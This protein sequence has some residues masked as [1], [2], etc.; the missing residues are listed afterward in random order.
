MAADLIPAHSLLI[1]AIVL[2]VGF[3]INHSVIGTLA[4]NCYPTPFVVV[5]MIR[6]PGVNYQ[7]SIGINL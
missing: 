4:R 3:F 5:R 2:K 7:G 1:Q 6:T